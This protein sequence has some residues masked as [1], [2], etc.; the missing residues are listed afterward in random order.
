MTREKI[1]NTEDYIA[2]L[3]SKVDELSDSLVNEGLSTQVIAAEENALATI[4]LD[5]NGN[6]TNL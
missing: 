1:G 2:Y 6:E 4:G 3:E 5:F